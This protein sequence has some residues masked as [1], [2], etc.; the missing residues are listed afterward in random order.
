MTDFFLQ[1]EWPASTNVRALVTTRA[2]GNLADHVGD[3]KS[4]VATRRAALRDHL[5]ADPLWLT[6][7]HGSRCV[8]A[9][10]AHPGVEA[11]AAWTGLP[12]CVCAVLTADCLPVMLCDDAGTKVAAAHAGWRGLVG[13]VVES[14]VTAMDVAPQSLLAWLGPAIGPAAFEV[15]D[16]VREAFMATDAGASA[17]FLAKQ[18]GK[19]LCDIYA[20]ARRRLASLGVTRI[21]GGNR[22]TFTETGQFYSYRR[23][24]QTGRMASLIWLV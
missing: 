24:R 2:F 15:G 6:Q 21:Y 13:G 5:P 4:A 7:V 12:G 16:D 20:L 17:A 3:E 9:E 18:N 10:T 22:C 1:P 8:A 23:E 14:T 19:W 11:D